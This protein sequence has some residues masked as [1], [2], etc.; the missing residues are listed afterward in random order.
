MRLKRYVYGI[1][2]NEQSFYLK[3]NDELQISDVVYS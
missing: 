2:I 1:Q 3:R